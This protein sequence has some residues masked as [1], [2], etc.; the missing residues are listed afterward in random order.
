MHVMEGTIVHVG[1]ASVCGDVDHDGG[2]CIPG[3]SVYRGNLLSAEHP[4]GEVEERPC[5]TVGCKLFLASGQGLYSIIQA[6]YEL[7][8]GSSKLIVS[9]YLI[10]VTSRFALFTMHLADL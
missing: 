6:L 9:R 10:N 8:F 5:L 1:Y 7:N 2:G 4:H 3:E